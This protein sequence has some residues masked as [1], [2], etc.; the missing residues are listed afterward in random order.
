M[1]DRTRSTAA[2][3]SGNEHRGPS[4][5]SAVRRNLF[6]GQLTRRPTAGTGSSSH[7]ADALRLDAD[8]RSD[9]SEIVVRDQH[10]EIDLGDPPTPVLEEPED[11]PLDDQQEHESE[12]GRWRSLEASLSFVC[13]FG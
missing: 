9:T 11:L 6:Q 12:S 4:T 5:T 7:A 2:S 10:G 1:A 3:S 8:V 13:A